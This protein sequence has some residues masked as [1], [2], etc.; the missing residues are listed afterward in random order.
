MD[1]RTK[2]YLIALCFFLLVALVIAI[3]HWIVSYF[4]NRR[5]KK[6]RVVF[7]K[8]KGR[9]KGFWVKGDKLEYDPDLKSEDDI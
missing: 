5:I 4:E 8:D 2:L 6:R 9:L 7:S 3:Y 1:S